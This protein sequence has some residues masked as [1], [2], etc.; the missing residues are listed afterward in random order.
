MTVGDQPTITPAATTPV[1]V[2]AAA[3]S[4][5]DA[6]AALPVDIA[7]AA[8]VLPKL[9]ALALLS[10]SIPAPLH[11]TRW[12]LPAL[13]PALLMVLLLPVARSRPSLPLSFRCIVAPRSQP[14]LCCSCRGRRTLLA[15]DGG[16][17]PLCCVVLL[18]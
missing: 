6:A 17:P 2:A 10:D 11:R 5:L 3:R 12:L 8:K 1:A 9:H 13:L 16:W 14:L 7:A 18:Q 4:A 15:S